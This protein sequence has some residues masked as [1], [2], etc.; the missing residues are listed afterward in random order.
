M[1]NKSEYLALILARQGSKRLKNKNILKL[2]KKPLVLWTLDNLNKL[3]YL[4]SDILVSSDSEIIQK[5][6]K[7][8]NVPFLKRPNYLSH[9][10]V[11][12][13]AAAFHAINFY[14]KKFRFIK[15]VILFQV[16]SPFRKNITIKKAIRLSKMFPNKQ[17]VAVNKKNL[18]PNGVIYLTPVNLLKKYKCFS[19]KGFIPLIINSE[20]E[21]LDI[22]YKTDLIK[23]KKYLKKN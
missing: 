11:T 19:H 12:S 13:E 8:K 17:I 15:Y 23:A 5:I 3:K 1:K 22:D 21:S 14:K 16:T 18:E 10:K 20:K 7:K 6:S 2:N 9:G 4:F